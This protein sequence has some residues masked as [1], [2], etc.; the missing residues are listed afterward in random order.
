MGGNDF[1]SACKTFEWKYG[2][3]KWK[4]VWICPSANLDKLLKGRFV[5]KGVKHGIRQ[6]GG[7]FQI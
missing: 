6:P 3:I 2:C 1:Y 4:A 7:E 5:K